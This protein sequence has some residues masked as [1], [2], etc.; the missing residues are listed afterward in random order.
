[1]AKKTEKTPV[2]LPFISP[3]FTSMWELYITH[4]REKGVGNYTQTGLNMAFKK[5]I[6]LSLDVEKTAIKILEQS[7]ENNW[8]GIF[9]LKLDN[10]GRNQSY[11]R[12]IGAGRISGQTVET[13]I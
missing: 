6:R 11:F 2:E 7:I 10:D 3:E 13:P 8:T 1:M 4:R 9:P 12:D 5:L